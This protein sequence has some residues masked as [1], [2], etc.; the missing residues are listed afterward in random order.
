MWLDNVFLFQ[1]KKSLLSGFLNARIGLTVPIFLS[2]SL[3][4]KEKV[5]FSCYP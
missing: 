4:Y 1:N 2:Y 5:A 3:I